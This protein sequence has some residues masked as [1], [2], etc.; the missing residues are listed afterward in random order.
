MTEPLTVPNDFAEIREPY[1]GPRTG[2][3]LSSFAVL[4]E[5]AARQRA[6]T[7]TREMPEYDGPYTG[8][9]EQLPR[10][11]QMA[12]LGT[13]ERDAVEQAAD[14]MVPDRGRHRVAREGGRGLRV[15][16][17]WPLLAVLAVQAVLSLRLVWSNTAFPDEALYLWAGHLEWSHWLHGTPLPAFPTYFS[18]APTVYPPVGALADSLGGL[19]GAR[20]LSLAF[21]LTATVLLYGTANQLFGGRSGLFA[22]GAFAAT[23]SV[24][25]LG[26]FA[27]YDAMALMLLALAAR[28]A[29]AAG[30]VK[31]AGQLAFLLSSGAVL[32]LADGAKYAAALWNPVVIA[33]AV[34]C[35]W[36]AHGRRR[37]LAAGAACAASLAAVAA[38]GLR[39]GGHPYWRGITFTTLSR[40]HGT[41]SPA[42]IAA[43]SLGWVGLLAFLAVLGAVVV[44][45]TQKNLPARL[46]AWVLVAAVALAPANQARIHVFTSLF[47]HVGF[48]AWFAA[49]A[50]GFALASLASAVPRV[51]KTAAFRASASAV[52]G[53]A[54]LG[55][56]LSATHFSTWPGS[57]GFISAV[58][59]VIGG[60]GPVLAA[61][62]GNVIE[63]YLPRQSAGAVFYGPWF[64]RYQDPRSRR[65]LVGK[66]AFA[67]AVKHRFFRVVALSFSDSQAVDAEISADIRKYGGYKLVAVLPYQ[68]ANWHSAYRV[69]VREASAK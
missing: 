58:S 65:W 49:A 55:G 17:C 32:A 51:K 34:L 29:V 39:L 14:A 40:Q 57:D 33:L 23:A 43:D 60:R 3:V 41:S 6:V 61:D 22:S 59:R 69:W 8:E 64:F 26:A 2:D 47:K 46:T 50:A 30:P 45:A 18:G 5:T 66:P 21:M 16:A 24:Q 10:G 56:L 68:V 13:L 15:P 37:G 25:F 42:G 1:T 36:K 63:Y 52:A 48:G 38:A 19:A 12:A 31:L 7:E 11:D 62:N 9:L 54:V 67:D 28:L 35:A 44:T 20:I 4:E 53:L 27:T